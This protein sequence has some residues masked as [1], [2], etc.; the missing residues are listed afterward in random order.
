MLNV[1]IVLSAL[2][3]YL[4]QFTNVLANQNEKLEELSKHI[5]EQKKH[6]EYSFDELSQNLMSFVDA[7]KKEYLNELDKQLFNLRYWYIYLDKQIKKTYP[8]PDD[9]NFLISH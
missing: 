1:R 3:K 9:V 2:P 5:E 6:V 4:D 7:K 8:T